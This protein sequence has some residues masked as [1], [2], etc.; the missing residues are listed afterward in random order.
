MSHKNRQCHTRITS[1]TQGSP[2]SHKDHQCH[3]RITSV[4][5]E[6]PMSH[7][8]HRCHTRITSVTQ[9][10]PVSHKN[11]QCHTRITSVTQ[12]SP[13]SHKD[14]PCHTRITSVTQGSPVSHKNHQCHTRITR[15]TQGSPV[16]HKNHQCHTRITSVTQGSPVSHK[17]H[18]CHTRI[19]TKINRSFTPLWLHKSLASLLHKY[20]CNMRLLVSRQKSWCHTE[21]TY[22]TLEPTAPSRK[23]LWL[24]IDTNHRLL[25]I[26]YVT[27]THGL[28]TKITG[29]TQ[30]SPVSHKNQQLLHARLF[31]STLIQIIGF[32]QSATSQ[33]LPVSRQESLVSHR[34]PLLRTPAQGYAVTFALTKSSPPGGCVGVSSTVDTGCVG[35]FQYSRHWLCR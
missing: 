13:V 26:S 19:N 9:E 35:D 33:R 7:K 23:T 3:T 34:S 25:T 29:V 5:Q 18:Q 20:W 22:V 30:E 27:E 15:V 16:S 21:I 4:T 1:V 12:G 10:S 11:H 14:H 6:S 32:S 2:V 28:L 8:D 31:G 24:H 17:D